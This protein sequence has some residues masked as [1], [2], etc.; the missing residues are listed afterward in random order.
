[1]IHKY[2]PAEDEDYFDISQYFEESYEFIEEGLSKVY[3]F[4]IF[5]KFLIDFYYFRIIYF[6]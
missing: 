4:F 2:F 1:M 6:F 3:Y 5:Y